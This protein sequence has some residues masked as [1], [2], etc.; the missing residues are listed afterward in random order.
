MDRWSVRTS[1]AAPHASRS[2]ERDKRKHKE[3][4]IYN[5]KYVT[6]LSTT[7]FWY[8]GV[9]GYRFFAKTEKLLLKIL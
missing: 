8:Y 1:H 6:P 4:E 5:T 3:Y 2:L 9:L 7:F